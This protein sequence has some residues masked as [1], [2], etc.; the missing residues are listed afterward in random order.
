[1]CAGERKIEEKDVFQVPSKS[2]NPADVMT[3]L[4]LQKSVVHC[5]FF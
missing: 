5:L 1:M 3:C 2:K 4:T